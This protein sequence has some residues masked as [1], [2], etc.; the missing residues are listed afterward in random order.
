MRNKTILGLG[1]LV[2][3]L[4]YP[5]PGSAG[6]LTEAQDIKV[7]VLEG[8]LRLSMNG[9]FGDSL[10]LT[11]GKMVIMPPNARRIPDPVTVDLKKVV[12]TSKLVNM[13]AKKDKQT[14]ANSAALPSM[15]KVEKAVEQQQTGKGARNLIDTNLV[16]LGKGT[17]VVMASDDL[18]H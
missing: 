2:S 15:V 3:F 1:L 8:S 4:I 17:D 6:P 14:N 5:N 13:Q 18:L 11:P 10:L 12:E 9:R 16:I 7:L